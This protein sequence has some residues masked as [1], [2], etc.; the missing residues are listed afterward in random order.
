MKVYY[1]W[2]FLLFLFVGFRYQVGC[3]WSGYNNI[4]RAAYFIKLD[5]A[6]LE[7]KEF[8]FWFLNKLLHELELEYPYIN[9]IASALFF[10]GLNAWSKRQ[11]DP[12]AVL[13]LA[14][15]VLILN[16]AMSGIRQAIATGVLCFAYN[17]FI[18]KRLVQ[19]IFLVLAAATFHTSAALFLV[20]TPLVRGEFTRSR[21]LLGTLLALPGAYYMVTSESFAYYTNRYIGERASEAAGGAYRASLLAITGV[22]FIVFLDTR[23]KALFARDYKFAKITSYMLVAALPISLYSSVI[24]DRFGY[25]LNPAQLMILARLPY[26]ITGTYAPVIAVVPYLVGAVVLFTWI[27]LST[28]F[29]QCYVPYQIWW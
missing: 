16:L 11:P 7:K 5:E 1:G 3:D 18:E 25:Y 17:A 10:A 15:P 13:I 24:G 21:A 9:V 22:A 14:F 23:W 20:L 19:Y 12:L 2:L 29:L 26:L 4:Y 8:S 28:M 6:I 27:S